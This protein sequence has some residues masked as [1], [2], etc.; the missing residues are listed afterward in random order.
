MLN[1][2]ILSVV[3]LNVVMLSVVVSKNM[4]WWNKIDCFS[5]KRPLN[6]HHIYKGPLLF[7]LSSL[8]PI[9]YPNYYHLGSELKCQNILAY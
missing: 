2:I 5:Y 6:H 7:F 3:M 1:V 8:F 9:Y 4:L